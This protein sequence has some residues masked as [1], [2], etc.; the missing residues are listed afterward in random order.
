MSADATI[1]NQN[2]KKRIS[3]NK[4]HGQVTL[5]AHALIALSDFTQDEFEKNHGIK[6]QFVIPPG[7][8]PAQFDNN[9]GEKDIDILAA[10]SLIP[11]KQY[12]IFVEVV[13]E[14][15]KQLP[16]IKVMLIG[17]GPEKEKLQGLISSSGL[18]SAITLT[19]EL[20]HNEV[21]QWMQRA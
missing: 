11:L 4:Y 2:F 13:A 14:I 5:K 15:K 1:F 18:Q 3:G 21:L 19:G 12:D 20:P 9:P 7:I 16:E 8:D 6:P 10:G 17:D